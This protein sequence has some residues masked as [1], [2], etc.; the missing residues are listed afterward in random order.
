[1]MAFQGDF[2]AGK[3]RFK[4]PDKTT[5]LQ[6]PK[7]KLGQED[8]SCVEKRGE[9]VMNIYGDEGPATNELGSQC[10]KFATP[11]FGFHTTGGTW[12]DLTLIEEDV[13]LIQT[14]KKRAGCGGEGIVQ[15]ADQV[16]KICWVSTLIG[17]YVI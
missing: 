1:M 12:E 6:R 5:N 14:K 4:L 7:P 17:G 15:S 16:G 10:D 9:V 13:P 11:S 2:F 8:T 3:R